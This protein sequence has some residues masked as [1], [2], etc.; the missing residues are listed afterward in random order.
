MSKI[1]ENLALLEKGD[2]LTPFETKVIK[3]VKDTCDSFLPDKKVVARIVGGWVR[4][5]LL[6]LESD[7][8]DF[9]IEG[10]DGLS[11]AKQME[12]IAPKSD[13]PELTILANPQQSAHIGSAKV[14]L[15]PEFYI[16]IC[17]LRW[18]E[19]SESRIPIISVGTPL[20]DAKR[21]DVT[22]NAIFL[23]INTQKV[24]DFCDGIQ[25]LENRTLRTCLPC[26]QS[27][28]DDPL[29]ILRVF[30]FGAKYNFSLD[31]EI[32]P[33]A[34]NAIEDYKQKI[35]AE[36]ANQEID[37][38]L[39]GP[40][41]ALFIRWIVESGLFKVIFD[42]SGTWNLDE[43]EVIRRITLAMK[44]CEE[45]RVVIALA[46][47]FQPLISHPKVKDTVKK[48]N[49]VTAIEFAVQ[50]EMKFTV[51]VS[52]HVVKLSDGAERVKKLAEKNELT[53]LSAGRFV[54][55][56]GPKWPLVRHLLFDQREVD[57]FVKDLKEFIIEQKL[58]DAY[59]IKPLM[60]GNQLA[61]A[62]GVKPGPGMAGLI[63]N[64]IEWQI[65]NPEG[66]AE[67]YIAELVFR[68]E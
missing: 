37:K 27:F 5:K 35:T 9:S 24:E 2:N 44:D 23:N 18:D 66:T 3:I 34:N 11:F 32:I 16:D 40:N 47:I 17:G 58:S 64:L 57:F 25:D 49:M 36:R 26:K 46:S 19:Y 52:S 60:R 53:R 30:R 33:C 45:E 48:N 55:E 39:K 56:T 6:G 54:L 65:E 41:S 50:R 28:I 10:I 42:P 29:R 12:K 8:I 7:D 63:K 22:V 21:R 62:L 59:N 1:M 68:S 20:Q 4:D 13:F 15:I 43:S 51:E 38:S 14:Y 61:N 31:K 67:Q